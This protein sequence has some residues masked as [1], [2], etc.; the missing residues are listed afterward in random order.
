[1][2]EMASG[3]T[4][5]PAKGRGGVVPYCWLVDWAHCDGER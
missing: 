4:G 5:E 2:G 1:V 3:R